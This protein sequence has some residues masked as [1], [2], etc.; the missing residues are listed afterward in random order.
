VTAPTRII[1]VKLI[2]L[3][4][5]DFIWVE[6]PYEDQDKSKHRPV[7]ILGRSDATSLIVCSITSSSGAAKAMLLNG[8]DLVSGTLPKSGPSYIRPNKIQTVSHELISKNARDNRFVDMNRYGLVNSKIIVK[9]MEVVTQLF[10]D[11]VPIQPMAFER[12]AK[13]RIR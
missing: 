6:F 2:D 1:P 10:I 9:V 3:K 7:L 5:G 12:P 8:S 4:R 13:T 11:D